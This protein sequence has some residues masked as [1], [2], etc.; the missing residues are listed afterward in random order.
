MGFYNMSK[1]DAPYLAELSRE[2]TLS[3]NTHQAFQGGTGANHVML[4]SG[5]AIAY[6][7]GKGNLTTPPSNLNNWYEQDGYSGGTYSNCSDATQPGVSAVLDYLKSL[8]YK[9]N[10]N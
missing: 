3:D 6:S 4:G 9:P 8:P 2:Y 1:G 5:D 7:D 10:P